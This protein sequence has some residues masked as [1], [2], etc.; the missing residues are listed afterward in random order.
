MTAESEHGVTGPLLAQLGT[1]VRARRRAADLTVQQL[2][3]HAGVS[4]RLLTQ[5]EQGQAN[6]SLVTVDK[7]A[8]A[9]GVDFGTLAGASTRDS[10]DVHVRQSGTEVWRTPAGSSATLCVSSARLGG[11]ELWR[12]TL[13]PGD[14]YASLSDPVGS[15]ELLLVEAGTLT[16]VYD[17]ERYQLAAGM[18]ARISNDRGYTYRNETDQPVVFV[19]VFTLPPR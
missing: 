5:I 13:A 6:P 19:R 16:F 15:E 8:R 3:D 2:A 14:D 18:S 9:L 7:L 1:E 4:R 12:W 11:P 10:Q 17:A